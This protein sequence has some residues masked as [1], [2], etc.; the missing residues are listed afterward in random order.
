L[1]SLTL[2]RGLNGKGRGDGGPTQREGLDAA[3]EDHHDI[4]AG[5]AGG[6][7]VVVAETVD[8]TERSRIVALW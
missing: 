3:M 5:A 7:K 1:S 6:L 2:W 8:G 4:R